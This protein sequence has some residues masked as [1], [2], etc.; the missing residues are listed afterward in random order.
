MQSMKIR[1]YR[2]SDHIEIANLVHGAVHSIPHSIYSEKEL[3]AWAPTPINYDYWKNRLASKKPFIAVSDDKIIGFIELEPD[4]Y[5]DCLYVHNAHQKN[6]I[7]SR[8]LQYVQTIAIMNGLKELYVEASKIAM[9]LFQRNGFEL[10][11]TNII[12]LRGQSFVNY[13]MRLSPLTPKDVR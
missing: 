8:L 12:S 6:G 2:D 10:T 13:G 11:S 7:A 5:I 1:D 3:E 9:P 4:G